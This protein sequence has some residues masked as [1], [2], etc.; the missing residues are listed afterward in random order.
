VKVKLSLRFTHRDVDVTFN[1]FLISL[2]E[3]TELSGSSSDR[4]SPLPPELFWKWW[5]E[6]TFLKSASHPAYLSYWNGSGR[7]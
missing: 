3:D 2:L 1:L 6:E 7:R 5:R 4:F